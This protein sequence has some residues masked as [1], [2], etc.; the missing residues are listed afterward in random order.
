M[1]KKKSSFEVLR[2]FLTSKPLSYYISLIKL[3]RTSKIMKDIKFAKVKTH[4]TH[5][6]NDTSIF[7]L[8]L[9]VYSIT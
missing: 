5:Y 2:L 1:V 6:L 9:K 4:Y 7:Y 8:E 3:Q